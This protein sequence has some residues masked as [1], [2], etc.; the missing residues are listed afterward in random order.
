MTL[1]PH[2]GI[3]YVWWNDNET[4]WHNEAPTE[5]IPTQMP[6]VTRRHPQ[7]PG[8]QIQR[9]PVQTERLPAPE[10]ECERHGDQQPVAV[11]ADRREKFARLIDRQRAPL[12]VIEPHWR[13]QRSDVPCHE[14]FA[15]GLD[16]GPAKRAPHYADR[17]RAVAGLPLRLPYLI[18]LSDCQGAESLH[19]QCRLQVEPSRVGVAVLGRRR[20]LAVKAGHPPI[21]KALGQIQKSLSQRL[22]EARLGL[23]IGL[24]DSEPDLRTTTVSTLHQLVAGMNLDNFVVRRHRKAV[25][26]FASAEAWKTIA[27]EDSE[28]LLAL[29]GLPSSVR[30]DDEDAKRFDLLILRR[31]LAQ[32]DG[33]AVLAERLRETVQHIAGALLGKTTIPSVAEQAVLL[34]SVAGDQWWIDV[35][36]PMLE[37]A[38][39]K[40]RS[41][42]RFIE[43]SQRN[44][45]YTDFEDTLGER[46]EIV[47]P[48]VRPGANF[49]RFRAKAESYL[50]EHL[51]DLALQRLRRNKQLTSDDLTELER[52][53]VA[54]GGQ[55][56]DI[57]WATE[58][59]GLGIFVRNLVGLDR[60]AAIEAFESYLDKTRF[61]ADQIRF[62][63]LIVDELTKNGV[64]QP[65]RL[66]ESPYTDHAP[67]RPDFFFP[68]SDVGIIVETLHQIQRHAAPQEVA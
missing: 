54:S 64:M 2:T 29:A 18:N 12:L 50:R 60:S 39:R 63:N 49:E 65:A 48:G 62:V 52:M 19:T 43:K 51:E 56:A 40:M 23:A 25:E 58:Q 20:D 45:V 9:R 53:L 36:R 1:W 32:L 10:P 22:F 57:A 41:L 14:A 28:V 31:Q 5:W 15:L 4:L 68:D 66:F 38:R 17:V 11:A 16:D 33:D 6:N 37:E 7:R 42:V 26:K 47:L 55:Q 30:D 3:S 44:P 8:V 27:P 34:E 35:T 24:G 61:S 46:V 21:E 13:G 59:G 67:T